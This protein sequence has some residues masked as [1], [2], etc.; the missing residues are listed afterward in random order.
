MELFYNSAG[1]LLCKHSSFG[2]YL[3]NRNVN[4]AGNILKRATG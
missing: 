2:P 1:H 4:V 3:D